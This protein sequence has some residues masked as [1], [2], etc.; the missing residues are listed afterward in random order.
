MAAYDLE[1]QEQL[2]QLKAFWARWGNFITWALALVLAAYA[3]WQGWQYWQLRQA[4]QAAA[5]LDELEQAVRVGQVERVKQVWA[6]L[7]AQ[8]ARTEQAR[9]GA[10]LAARVLAEAGQ[11]ESARAA[12]QFVLQ[13]RGDD[14]LAALARLRLAG[15]AI[16]TGQL[17]EAQRLLQAPLPAA[18]QPWR[19]DRLGDLRQRQGQLQ[20]AQEAYLQAWRGMAPEVAYRSLVEAKLNA[21]GVDPAAQGQQP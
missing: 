3:A 8:A 1:E 6:D 5:L 21:L 9:L 7:Q 10:L 15:L 12:L 14:E 20:A 4:Q 19:D 13:R 11:G 18:L 16:D 17:D 2:A